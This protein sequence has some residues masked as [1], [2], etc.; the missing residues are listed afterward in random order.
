M[1]HQLL[2]SITSC[3][4]SKKMLEV[5]SLVLCRFTFWITFFF[6]AKKENRWCLVSRFKLSQKE[7][8]VFLDPSS[9]ALSS[10]SSSVCL[11]LR[12]PL[13][14]C[15]GART[16]PESQMPF[17]LREDQLRPRPHRRRNLQLPLQERGSP[18]PGS[19]GCNAASASLWSGVPSPAESSWRSLSSLFSGRQKDRKKKTS[20]SWVFQVIGV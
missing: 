20:S 18:G 14:V 4:Q 1:W 15:F 6:L 11:D 2:R 17:W 7:I 8:N 19:S 5:F 16:A 9:L 12:P 13:L 3:Y 10:S